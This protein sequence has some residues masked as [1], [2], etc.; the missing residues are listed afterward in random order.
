MIVFAL[1]KKKLI[2]PPNLGTLADN[3]KIQNEKYN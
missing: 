1:F 2:H 3:I